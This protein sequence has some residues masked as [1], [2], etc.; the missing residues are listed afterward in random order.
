MDFLQTLKNLQEDKSTLWVAKTGKNKN[1]FDIYYKGKYF[2][3]I[4]AETSSRAIQLA[5]EEF[6]EKY[7]ESLIEEGMKLNKQAKETILKFMN[8]KASEEEKGYIKKWGF[9]DS[10]GKL[11]SGIRD[12]VLEEAKVELSKEEEA[13]IKRVAKEAFDKAEKEVA[14]KMGLT[15]PLPKDTPRAV[16]DKLYAQVHTKLKKKS[17]IDKCMDKLKEEIQKYTADDI[18][19]EIMNDKSIVREFETKLVPKIKKEKG[20]DFSSAFRMIVDKF[21]R[22]KSIHTTQ[23]D[24]NTATSEIY[25]YYKNEIKLGN[26]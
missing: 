6:K 10:K 1:T 24:V 8:G 21:L 12:S 25:N 2:T 14:D 19:D 3:N 17:N 26:F 9:L 20:S 7:N 22:Q 5:K 18:Y 23:N 15:L 13:D 16:R 4:G 11:K